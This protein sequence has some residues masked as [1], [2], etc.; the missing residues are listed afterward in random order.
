[1]RQRPDSATEEIAKDIKAVYSLCVR[2]SIHE[3]SRDAAARGAGIPGHRTGKARG[4]LVD[5]IITHWTFAILPSVIL[6][7]TR[8]PRLEI[9]LLEGGLADVP[10]KKIARESIKGKTPGVAQA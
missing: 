9:D 8:S 10:D 5:V 6:A 1:M 2:S 4:I 3:S 7:T